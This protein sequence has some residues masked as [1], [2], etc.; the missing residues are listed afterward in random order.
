MQ[1][2]QL[3]KWRGDFGDAYTDRDR[4]NANYL[5]A[6]CKAWIKLLGDIK[7]TSVLEVGSGIG[8][9]LIA[10]REV[11][12]A[13]LWALEP[14]ARAR[15]GLCAR[16]FPRDHILDGSAQAIPLPD[17]SI[18]L[19]FTCGVLIHI[20]PTDLLA[21][22]R[23]IHRC[24]RTHIICM[25]YFADQP[26]EKLYRGEPGL[27]FKRDFG[28]FWMDHFALTCIDYG[29]IWRRATGLDNMNWWSFKKHV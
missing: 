9:N 25:E 27:L 6:L 17:S 11:C 15:E 2:D 21:A 18:D 7:P 28:A 16:G 14:N 1:S 8:H 10:I 23:E 26:E 4:F 12:D 19:V 29:F 20:H 22:C 5:Q 13:E 3:T 24:A